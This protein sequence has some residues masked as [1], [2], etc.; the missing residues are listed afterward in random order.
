[1]YFQFESGLPY[2]TDAAGQQSGGAS[3][4]GA[5]LR[6]THVG[7]CMLRGGAET[8]L[9]GLVRFLDPARVRVVRCLVTDPG[10]IDPQVS[11]AMGVPVE[12]GG[13]EAVRQASRDSDV[14]LCW[15]PGELADWLGDCRPRLAVFVAHGEGAWTRYVVGQCAPVLDHVVG[16]SHWV[17][18]RLGTALPLTCIPNGV[19]AARLGPTRPRAAMRAELG[20]GPEDFVLGYIG[21]FV[22]EKRPELLVEVVARLPPPF[23]ALFVGWGALR[24][25]V[26]ELAN[27]RIP[28]RYTFTTAVANVGDYYAALDALCLTSAEEGHGL[29]VLEAMMCGRPVIGTPVGC[30]PEV[31]E[32][33]VNGLVARD[34]PDS[35][36]AA[37]QLLY[38]R[39]EW[40]RGLAA[41]GRAF[42]L[43]HG[44]ARTMA[45]RYEELLL[46]LWREKQAV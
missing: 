18:A 10:L 19:D 36:A 27:E 38:R 31:I 30:V 28:G 43:E 34:G 37:A 13:R 46:R 29:V 7:P 11:A 35:F 8:W 17:S 15:G 9:Q 14:L 42:A 21:R 45:R 16:V 33:R 6:V 44:H 12:A 22:E 20:F 41:E 24:A 39:P 25:R 23:K 1:M 32:D 3:P 2:A 26:L 4:V 5:P 40:A